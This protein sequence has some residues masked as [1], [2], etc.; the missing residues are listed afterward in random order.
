MRMAPEDMFFPG[1][2]SF[3]WLLR[4]PV[5]LPIGGS[6]GSGKLCLCGCVSIDPLYEIVFTEKSGGKSQQ[7][8][9]FGNIANAAQ[10]QYAVIIRGGR[11]EH[12]SAAFIA[13]TH[14]GYKQKAGIV[15]ECGVFRL[16][17]GFTV[18]LP[19][20]HINCECFPIEDVL[21]TLSSLTHQIQNT[22]PPKES[23]YNINACEIMIPSSTKIPE[24][25]RELPQNPVCVLLFP[26]YLF[27]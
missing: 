18:P 4:R 17:P 5:C 15:L 8:Q 2:H 25:D 19:I 13:M 23:H 10:I 16:L 21:R 24:Y 11:T 9:Y 6:G 22:V 26:L 1:I 27:V 12:E 7:N 14:T 3:S 20:D